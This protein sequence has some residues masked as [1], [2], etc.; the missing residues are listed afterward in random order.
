MRTYLPNTDGS[1]FIDFFSLSFSNLDFFIDGL[2]RPIT[3]QLFVTGYVLNVLNRND[4]IVIPANGILYSLI[5][6]WTS[7]F[8]ITFY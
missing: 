5:N 8:C 2:L 3:T 6:S 7:V 4:F 1:I